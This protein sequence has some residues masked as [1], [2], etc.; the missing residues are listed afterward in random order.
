[1]KNKSFQLGVQLP[2]DTATEPVYRLTQ[3]MKDIRPEMLI[4][5]MDMKEQI[6]LLKNGDQLLDDSDD[7]V[8][9]D[10]GDVVKSCITVLSDMNRATE[11]SKLELD[12]LDAAVSL[13]MTRFA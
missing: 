8:Y 4:A 12:N 10:M 13:V 11:P 2:T 7:M 3:N 5:L 9:E 6:S 1:M